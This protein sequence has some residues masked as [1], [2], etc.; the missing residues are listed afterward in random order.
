MKKLLALALSFLTATNAN[1]QNA[2]ESAAPEAAAPKILVAYYSWSGN[3]KE[4]AEAIHKN[5]GGDLFAIETVQAYP[6]EY[7]ETTEQ[8]KKRLTPVIIRS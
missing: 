1:A 5:I 7:R 8:A 4:V 6:E 3:T 2:Q